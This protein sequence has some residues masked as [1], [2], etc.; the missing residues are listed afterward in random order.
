MATP[1]PAKANRNQPDAKPAQLRSVNPFNGQT[2][3]TYVEMTGEETEAAIARAHE[4]FPTWRRATFSERATALR[5]AAA[6][7]R[8]RMEELDPRDGQTDRRRPQGS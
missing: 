4:R 8:Q 2:L 7:C 1:N 3:K 6:L 5:G